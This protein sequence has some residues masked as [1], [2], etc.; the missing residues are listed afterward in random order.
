MSIVSDFFGEIIRKSSE[1]VTD[2]NDIQYRIN[3]VAIDYTH[4]KAH[5]G[6]VHYFSNLIFDIGNNEDLEVLFQPNG[7]DVRMNFS[8][9]SSSDCEIYFNEDVEFSASGTEIIYRN[10]NRNFSDGNGVLISDGPT[11]SSTGVNLLEKFIPSAD[12]K[13]AQGGETAGVFKDASVWVLHPQ[14]DYSIRV[15]NDSG[16]IIDKLLIEGS[17]YEV[18]A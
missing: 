16:G 14:K 8:V 5:K 13:E 17:F 7:S 12:K 11:I 1:A 18:L 6:Q 4:N 2:N 15:N 3:T 10:F 9:L